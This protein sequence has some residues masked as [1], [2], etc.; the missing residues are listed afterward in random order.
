MIPHGTVLVVDD[1]VEYRDHL[2]S[3]LATQGFAVEQA[4][5]G[6]QAVRMVRRDKTID[7]VVLER[8]VAGMEEDRALRELK[9]FRPEVQVII[10]TGHG[11]IESA[12][13]TGR[14]D[15]FAYLQKP[16]EMDE[17]VA[18]ITALEDNAQERWLLI[19]G[20]LVLAGLVLGA[21]IKA[22]PQRSAWS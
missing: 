15:A 9:E 12:T 3:A 17:L 14:M 2:A 6:N 19:G 10:L 13:E 11:S 18:T 5:T 8:L 16:C 1:D 21:A 20:G 22:R 7:V 4:T